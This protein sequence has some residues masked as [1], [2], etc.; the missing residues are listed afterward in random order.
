MDQHRH[1]PILRG[2]QPPPAHS[3]ADPRALGERHRP[4]P[5]QK[6]LHPLG[7]PPPNRPHKLHGQ[8]MERAGQT[9]QSQREQS[10]K[11]I[12]LTPS[13][14]A[15]TCPQL[16][17]RS[18]EQQLRSPRTAQPAASPHAVPGTGAGLWLQVAPAWRTHQTHSN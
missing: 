14:I 5:Q 8:E 6:H 4:R 17:Q 18:N 12:L 15:K 9:P 16:Q 11:P 13:A 2:P 7:R 10:Q 3:Q 1:R